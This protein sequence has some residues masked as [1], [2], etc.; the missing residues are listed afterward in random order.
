[1]KLELKT[2]DKNY[3]KSFLYFF[4]IVFILTVT[5]ILCNFAIKL[6]II[7]RHYQIEYNCRL[8]SFEKSKTYFQ[9]LSKLS[10]LKSKQR[11]WEFCKE[12]VK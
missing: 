7:S 9:N 2:E 10:Q 11:I 5:I 8:L 4:S 3:S 1:M 6:G 12:V